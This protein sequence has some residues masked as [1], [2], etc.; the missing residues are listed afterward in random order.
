MYVYI[1]NF[2]YRPMPCISK[3]NIGRLGK[4][5]LGG[6]PS[7]DFKLLLAGSGGGGGSITH[8]LSIQ[9]LGDWIDRSY[10]SSEFL[11]L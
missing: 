4:L 6:S 11:L 9:R 2:T 3:S 8:L 1:V 10:R 7:L 5:E